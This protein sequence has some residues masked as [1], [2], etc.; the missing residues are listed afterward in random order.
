V[1]IR[2]SPLQH[3]SVLPRRFALKRALARWGVVVAKSPALI[4][5]YPLGGLALAAVYFKF[6]HEH[7][8]LWAPLGLSAV[9]ATLLGVRKYK[10][11]RPAAWYL[12]AAGLF[13][14]ITGDTV[15]NVLT[16]VL[17]QEDP[18]PS[19]ADAFYL[20]MYPLFVAGLFIL[21]RARTTTRDWASMIDALTMATGMGL[22]SWV[23]LISPYLEAD[24]LSW[25]TRATSIAYP[26]A[27]VVVLATL[28]RLCATGLRIRSV[29]LLALAAIGL[30]AAD[31]CYGWIQ[32]N[33]VWEV[34]GPVDA[35]WVV[36][37]LGFGVAAL[38]P[39]MRQVTRPIPP[40]PRRL[41]GWQIVLLGAVS[42]IAPGVLALEAATHR[43]SH[44]LVVAVFSAA[45][46]LLVIARL[47]GI[48]AV[49]KQAVLRERVLRRY[50]ESLVSATS[51]QEVYA[52]TIS[53]VTTAAGGA[54]LDGAALYVLAE[55]RLESVASTTEAG[56][57]DGDLWRIAADGG[58]VV[59]DGMASVTPLRYDGGAQ[60]MIVAR[61][62]RPAP[63]E[64]HFALSAIGS[65]AGLALEGLR[66][67]AE[68]RKQQQ[69]AQFKALIQNASDLL[70][71]VGAD[72]TITYASP[73]VERR[74]GREISSLD[75]ASVFGL[76]APSSVEGARRQIAGLTKHAS[77]ARLVAD[78]TLRHADG[79]AIA[80][81]VVVQ[82]LLDDPNVAGVV[83]TMRDVSERREL[84]N[85]LSYQA[86]HDALTGLANRSLFHDRA[87]HALE[88][89]HRQGGQ[90]AMLM[91]DLDDFK[92]INDSLGH[93]AG[94]ELLVAVATYLA[95][96]T[97]SGG[98][99]A[100]LGGDEFAVLL[101]D[102]GDAATA[103]QIAEA[104]V[105]GLDQPFIVQD[106][107]VRAGAS[108]G[109]AMAGEQ[110]S[111]ASVQELLRNADLALYAAKERGRSVVV[112]YHDDLQV[113]MRERV[114]RK[115]DLSRAIDAGEFS[116]RYQPIISIES[117][118]IVGAEALVR[119]E[120]PQRGLVGPNEFIPAAEESGLIVDLGRWILDEACREAL[121]WPSS[122]GR[123]LRIS[124]NVSPLQ[125][126]QAGFAEHVDGILTVHPSLRHSLV[127]EITESTL[128]QDGPAI[129]EQMHIL[130][131]LGA[132]IAIDD[133]GVGYSSLGY[134]QR[135]PIDILKIDKSFVDNL[136]GDAG[137]GGVLAHAVLSMA[138]ALRLHA[139]AEGIEQIN[140]HDELR[141]LGCDFGQGYLYSRPLPAD[142]FQA[143]LTNP[144]PPAP[145]RPTR[146][147]DPAPPGH[148]PRQRRP[149]DARSVAPAASA[150]PGNRS[151]RP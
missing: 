94:D 7:L 21:I 89:I 137:H 4:Y 34:G 72:G 120:H 50:G 55:G 8:Q 6:P 128:V 143:L 10:P 130:H 53:A 101:E 70:I 127:L 129:P 95:Q 16:D 45:M 58:G 122:D 118:E 33:G 75:G 144:A 48:V 14:F 99:V 88:R 110:V 93:A 131:S 133:F 86:F 84:E 44:P 145:L 19:V 147:T 30:L 56:G 54:K 29:Q 141:A 115:S 97:P 82:H 123:R 36:C 119:W 60:G 100:R 49:H 37:Y 24:G 98:T 77:G 106:G 85:R 151:S 32:L 92:I 43:G 15:Y 140:Q 68:A 79:E 63:A 146:L 65:H 87:E 74:L 102:I 17:H 1:P 40:A 61:F 125:L 116:L 31:V 150:E 105:R 73:S 71:V 35:G 57:R 20:A 69:D 13:C 90:L 12:F 148:L 124:V 28:A 126:Q 47:A 67:S 114:T 107:E 132:L 76:L 136:S 134:L 96:H 27:D 121:T 139:V 51:A 111:V 39:S 149:E 66:L 103:Q 104:L 59:E 52:A 9:G 46:Y 2:V 109:L 23:Y 18:F 22:L 11:A 112:R 108:C 113:R 5:G 142:Q 62:R 38:H 64:I 42:L 26:V 91:L 80:F 83:L 78:W 117:G 25:L 3:G 81:E 41:R 135:F 138:H